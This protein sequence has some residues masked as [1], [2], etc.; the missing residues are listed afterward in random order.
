[1][2]ETLVQDV[3]VVCSVDSCLRNSGG[4][5]GKVGEVFC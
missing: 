2:I 4:E 5:K 1:M 3:S